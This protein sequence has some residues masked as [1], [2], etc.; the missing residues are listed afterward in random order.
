MNLN[1]WV[2]PCNRCEQYKLCDS[3]THRFFVVLVIFF[4]IISC[5]YSY[6]ESQTRINEINVRM[7]HYLNE[8]S[9]LRVDVV[10][11]TI[12]DIGIYENKA[13]ELAAYQVADNIKN[14]YGGDLNSLHERF[15][16]GKY[17]DDRFNKIITDAILNGSS[18]V[19]TEEYKNT[20]ILIFVKDQLLYNL[21][22]PTKNFATDMDDFTRRSF[23]QFL[24]QD[25]I[26][27]IRKV[28]SDVMIIE[29]HR[30]HRNPHTIIYSLTYDQIRDII[31]S[32]GID[33]LA[34][35]YVV[36]PSYITKTGDIFNVNDYDN[37][38][39]ANNTFKMAI[40]PYISL[41]DYLIKYRNHHLKTIDS[42]E[43][44]AKTRAEIDTRN[45]YYNSIGSVTVHLCIIFFLLN[46]S[47]CL[48]FRNLVNNRD[49]EDIEKKLTDRV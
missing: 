49:L 3:G 4:I 16:Q 13:S 21:M 23:N 33:G 37:N 2:P 8:I 36:K 34:G 9:R 22:F 12:H 35:Y 28:R 47:R 15:K 5:G 48:F 25:F 24:S 42:L 27:M 11:N 26:D 46:I 40:V 31:S 20:G 43:K 39:I 41:Y 44:E 32:E 6:I 10:Y 45:A 30:E 14:T 7:H 1:K 38:G 19:A 18:I 29:P 17:T